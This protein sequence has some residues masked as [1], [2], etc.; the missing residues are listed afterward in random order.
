[1]VTAKEA[2]FSAG[3][4]PASLDEP[5]RISSISLYFTPIGQIS[6]RAR[7]DMCVYEGDFTAYLALSCRVV[8]FGTGFNLKAAVRETASANFKQTSE[9]LMQQLLQDH[10]S[11]ETPNLVS[12]RILNE[13]LDLLSRL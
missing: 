11:C 4:L 1:M 10:N 6:G 13:T 9:E 3:T 8:Q 12:N 7:V 5:S 2:L